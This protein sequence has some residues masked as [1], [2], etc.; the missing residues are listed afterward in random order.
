MWDDEFIALKLC[1][2]EIF[3]L[4]VLFGIEFIVGNCESGQ[5]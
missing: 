2:P 4:R 5:R 1:S 3:S